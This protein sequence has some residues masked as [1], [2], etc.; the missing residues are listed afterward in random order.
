MTPENKSRYWNDELGRWQSEGL[1]TPAQASKILERLSTQPLGRL[2]LGIYSKLL[3][4]LGALLIGEGMVLF[5]SANWR[6]I[7]NIF[8][9]VLIFGSIIS[10]YVLGD[11]L[12]FGKSPLMGLSAALFFKGALA[13]GVGIF[14]VAQIYNFHAEWRAGILYWFLGSLPLAYVL[15]SRPILW[16]S[17]G[18]LLLWLAAGFSLEGETIIL[19]QALGAVLVLVAVPHW[20]PW[21]FPRFAKIYFSL[22]SALILTTTLWMA[23]GFFGAS[24]FYLEASEKFL[25]YYGVLLTLGVVFACGIAVRCWELLDRSRRTL[26]LL[27]PVVLA[28]GILHVSRNAFGPI[29]GHR[30]SDA[31]L[32]CV[33]LLLVLECVGVML[34]GDSVGTK[35]YLYIGLTYFLILSVYEYF[36]DR[37][38]YL[39]RSLF[40]LAGGVTLVLVGYFFERKRRERPAKSETSLGA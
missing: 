34:F 25:W 28:P 30:T 27:L 6:A 35:A 10:A 17:L 39:T 23:L 16:L 32:A 19:F 5:I 3:A 21:P 14:L 24:F 9:L 8:K 26:V 2:S 37:W 29:A 4:F 20:T 1:I 40:F 13:F 31:E 22:G 12:R 11:R 33:T 18:T 38:E 36:N 15:G 7:P